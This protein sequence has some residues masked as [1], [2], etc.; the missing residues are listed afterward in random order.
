[1]EGDRVYRKRPLGRR[2]WW[3]WNA[4]LIGAVL[5]LAAARALHHDTQDHHQTSKF[6]STGQN[7]QIV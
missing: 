4:K 2:G 3:F 6:N 5:K 7:G 1:M